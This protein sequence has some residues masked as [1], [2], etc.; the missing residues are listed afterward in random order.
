MHDGRSQACTRWR[1]AALASL[2]LIFIALRPQTPPMPPRHLY[3]PACPSIAV[4]SRGLMRACCDVFPKRPFVWVEKPD[5]NGLRPRGEHSTIDWDTVAIHDESIVYVPSLE[6]AAF[7]R[8]F[9]A[10]PPAARIT[11]VSGG[12]DIG[13]PREV[14]GHGVNGRRRAMVANISLSLSEFINDRRLLHWWVQN[15]DLV[16]C[17]VWNGCAG[18]GL[19]RLQYHLLAR[20][21]SP[22]PIGLDLHKFAE[23]GTRTGES[24]F[25][26]RA[27]EQHAELESIRQSLPAFAQR[28]D[29]LLAPF[30]CERS[31][32]KPVCEALKK[33]SQPLARFFFGSRADTWRA[34]GAHAFVVAPPGHGLDTHRAWEVLA[35]GSV[36]VVLS[37]SLDALY[38]EFPVVMIDSWDE[39]RTGALERWRAQITRRFGAEPFSERIRDALTGTHW[40][41][42]IATRHQRDLDGGWSLVRGPFPTVPPYAA[43][44]VGARNRST[45]PG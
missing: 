26:K 31:D 17:N 41:R 11:L 8:R 30:S 42:R 13:Q 34:M 18:R 45:S 23:R 35:L 9:V 20:K 3:P 36:P 38:S 27:C 1:Q 5:P 28:P 33:G 24:R 22:L 7:I 29:A 44:E 21:V 2:A 15:Y 37:S 25:R 6:I 4:W 40:A 39:V 12:E 32:R 10:L 19:Y 43:G 14:F 16:G